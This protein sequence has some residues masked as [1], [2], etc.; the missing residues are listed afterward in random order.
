M[1]LVGFAA[2]AAVLALAGPAFATALPFDP[3]E[4]TRQ[5]LATMG[6]EA[7]E[8]SNRYF[9]GGYIIQFVGPLVSIIISFALLALG[10]AKG[11]RS[12]LEKTV[13]FYFLDALGMGF[14]YSFVSTVLSISSSAPPRR[15]GGCGAR[16][17]RSPSA[18]SSR[19]LTLSI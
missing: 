7:T 19:S 4:A 1:R 16:S 15:R 6:P 10:W 13:K 17:R 2:F 18:P 12:W 14:F 9:E 3:D 8:R 5:W 11:V